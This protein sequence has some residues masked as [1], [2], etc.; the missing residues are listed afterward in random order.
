[1]SSN[2]PTRADVFTDLNLTFTDSYSAAVSVNATT[3]T[4]EVKPCQAWINHDENYDVECIVAD[5]ANQMYDIVGEHY[6]VDYKYFNSS[7]IVSFIPVPP[8]PL[9]MMSLPE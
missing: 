9:W 3:N 8:R 1:M 4:Y 2:I 6:I 7:Y 5:W